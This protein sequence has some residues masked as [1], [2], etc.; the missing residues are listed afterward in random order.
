MDAGLR[1]VRRWGLVLLKPFYVMRSLSARRGECKHCG[2]CWSRKCRYFD[3]P[4]CLRWDNL[5][6]MCVLYP[7]DEADKTPFA[8]EHCGFYWGE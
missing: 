6:L 2:C 3:D 7:I 1:H 8:K 4:D 5:P